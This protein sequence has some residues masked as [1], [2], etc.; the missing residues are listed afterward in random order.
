MH[1]KLITTTLLAMAAV[2]AIASGAFIVE[3]SSGGDTAVYMDGDNDGVITGVGSVGNFNI[4]NVTAAVSNSPGV[5]NEATL[6]VTNISITNFFAGESTLTVRVTDTD[7]TAPSGAVH[8][9]SD[10][11]GTLNRGS[12]PIPTRTVTF[13]S[14]IDD[15]NTAFG[16]GPTPGL[17]TATATGSAPQSTVTGSGDVNTTVVGSYSLTNVLTITVG[18][19]AAANISGSATA[20]PVPEPLAA[21]AAGLM[22][23]VALRR[24][25]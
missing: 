20:I 18:G 2:P 21:G 16:V 25:R 8:L 19:G 24:R 1:T 9:S 10:F 4:A 15:S 14:F 17:L 22:G 13:Q 23:L 11:G 12:N 3:V 7:F 5:A 6:Q